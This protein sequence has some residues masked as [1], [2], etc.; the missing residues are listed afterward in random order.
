M[1]IGIVNNLTA[2]FF[3]FNRSNCNLPLDQSGFELIWANVKDEIFNFTSFVFQK[4]KAYEARLQRWII[5]SSANN[6]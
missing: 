5:L 1:W 4:K 2:D 3:R 6:G